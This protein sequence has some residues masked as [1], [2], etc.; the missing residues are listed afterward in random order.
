MKTIHDATRAARSSLL[1][2]LSPTHF[3]HLGRFCGGRPAGSRIAYS[4]IDSE[5][6]RTIGNVREER[7]E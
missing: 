5:G 1:R 6:K 2:E 3:H 4:E 7:T